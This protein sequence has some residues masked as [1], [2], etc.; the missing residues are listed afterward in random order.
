[1]NYIVN[2]NAQM[3]TGYHKIHTTDCKKRPKRENVIDLKE[4]MCPFE[5][6]SRAKEYYNNVNGCKYCC[7][8]LFYKN[9]EGKR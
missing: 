3:G 6:K 5:A 7:K 1:M 2:K 4:C 9:E 8:Q